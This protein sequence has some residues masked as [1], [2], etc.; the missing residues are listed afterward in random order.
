MLRNVTEKLAFDST[1]FTLFFAVSRDT[2]MTVGFIIRSARNSESVV[3][4]ARPNTGV[5]IAGIIHSFWAEGR[6]RLNHFADAEPSFRVFV[7]TVLRAVGDVCALA[8]GKTWGIQP[9]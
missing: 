8:A 9:N 6:T 2:N 7:A 1:V 4:V 3:D 5:D